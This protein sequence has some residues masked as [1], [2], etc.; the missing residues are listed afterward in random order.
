VAWIQNEIS[1]IAASSEE[2]SPPQDFY[3]S[4]YDEDEDSVMALNT[5]QDDSFDNTKDEK[6][7]GY[8][9]DPRCFR[10]CLTQ[11]IIVRKLEQFERDRGSVGNFQIEG[12]HD[13]VLMHPVYVPRRYARVPDLN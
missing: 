1:S 8:A 9:P 3:S 5:S 4:P 7:F 13:G 12:G 6:F 2:P 11:H 10:T